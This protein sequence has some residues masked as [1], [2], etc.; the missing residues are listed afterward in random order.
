MSRK[1]PLPPSLSLSHLGCGVSHPALCSK[2]AGGR[3][4][5]PRKRPSPPLPPPSLMYLG[6][7]AAHHVLLERWQEVGAMCHVR[8]PESLSPPPT[9]PVGGR[10]S[11]SRE[12]AV[13]G[14]MGKQRE[15]CQ[16]SEDICG[17][18]GEEEPLQNDAPPWAGREGP[19]RVC[20]TGGA[21][22]PPMAGEGVC[23]TGGVLYR[24]CFQRRRIVRI[25]SAMIGDIWVCC[26]MGK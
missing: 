9:P 11:A 26:D 1:P 5:S 13:M 20:S 4:Y 8:R 24:G 12:S 10:V 22:P 15:G 14:G 23:S 6:C 7:G 3:S 21:T 19:S 16:P 18:W 2:K 25:V 17:R